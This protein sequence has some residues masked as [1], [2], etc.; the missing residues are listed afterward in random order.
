MSN[1]RIFVNNSLKVG[2][3]VDIIDKQHHYLV[4]VMRVKVGDTIKLINGKDGEF[5][6]NIIFSN[7]KRL[8]LKISEKIKDFH[9]KKF[10]GLIFSPIQKIDLLLK[11]ATEIGTTD[12]YPTIMEY[13]NKTN[14]KY[15]RIKDNIIEAVEQSERIDLPNIVKTV[16]LNER[17][18]ELNNEKNIIFFC[19]ERTSSNSPLNIYNNSK[20]Y[21]N[22]KNI[23]VLIGPEGGFSQK[24]KEII[25]SFKNIISINLGDTILRSETATV[26]AL[27]IIKAFYYI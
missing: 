11:G 23:Y 7:K 24:E 18:Q 17:L 16:S 19:E 3:E 4:N 12:F 13:T 9:T 10:L 21:I 27:S 26:S 2:N 14:I 22:N 8:V 20:D 15:N 5:L 25:N 1:I 6:S